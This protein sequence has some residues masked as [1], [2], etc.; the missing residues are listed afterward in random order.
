MDGWYVTGGIDEDAIQ[1]LEHQRIMDKNG[2]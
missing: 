1:K 2:T